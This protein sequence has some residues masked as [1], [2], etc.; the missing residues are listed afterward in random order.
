[1]C[2]AVK[3]CYITIVSIIDHIQSDISHVFSNLVV[4][5]S[6]VLDE[7]YVLSENLQLEMGYGLN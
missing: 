6:Y 7:H 5:D 3:C 1:M 2:F 4:L